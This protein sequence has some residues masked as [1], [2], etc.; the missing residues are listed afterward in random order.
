MLMTRQSRGQSRREKENRWPS[1]LCHELLGIFPQDTLFSFFISLSSLIFTVL[2][3]F[4][5]P[6][7]MTEGCAPQ[8][9]RITGW[10]S[11]V[12]RDLHFPRSLLVVHPALFSCPWK[13]TQT[14]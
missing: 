12:S 10:L 7:E 4:Y 13:M 8:K 1:H 14:S 3:F 11:V 9:I 6:M 5:L 2:N